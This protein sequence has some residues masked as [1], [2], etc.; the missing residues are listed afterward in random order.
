MGAQQNPSL[1]FAV[2]IL[3]THPPTFVPFPTRLP[4]VKAAA[5]PAVA[6]LQ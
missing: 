5:T 3:T 6:A 4:F 2:N 1:H